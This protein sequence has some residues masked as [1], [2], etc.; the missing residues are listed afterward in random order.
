MSLPS[1]YAELLRPGAAAVVIAAYL[2]FCAAMAGTQWAKRRRARHRTAVPADGRAPL[3]IA[4]ASQTGFA[5]QLATHTAG[6]LQTAGVPARLVTL[7]EIGAADLAQA[8]RALFIASTCGE[9][10]APDNASLFVRRVMSEKVSLSHLHVG[11]LALGDREYTHFC[12][13]G[14]RLDAWL[15][16]SGAQPLF[17]RIDVHNADA[18]ALAD[19]QHQLSHVAGTTDLPDWQAP[20]WQAWRLAARRHLNPGSAGGP[21][22]HLELEP[23]DGTLPEWQAGDLVQVSPP[24][25]PDR[26]REYSIASL[27]TEGRVQLLVRQERHTDGQLGLASGWLTWGAAVGDVVQL[28]LRPHGNFRQTGNEARQLIL[29]GN[30]TGLA[31][32]LGHVK[33]RAAVGRPPCWL[34]FG[35]RQAGHDAYHRD[36][37]EQWVGQGVLARA[38]LVFSRD[39]PERLYV[40]HRLLALRHDVLRWVDEGAAIYVC[41]SLEGMAGAVHAA[42]G[43]I[44][45]EAGL[46]RLMEEGRYRR[47][48]Y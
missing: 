28:R 38:D 15:R 13:F 24:A 33:A 6:L 3:L 42:L 17:D 18:E 25:D 44:L 5:E 4:Y 34:L 46:D 22:F 27:P 19:W 23:A 45:G 40:Q 47:D 41:G 43:D 12:A 20:A 11:V 48:V 1:W 37:I 39:H 29:I 26:P 9:G 7:S 35:E 10:D 8:E 36:L 14:Q 16:E 21:T 2:V 30:G 31:G 32:L